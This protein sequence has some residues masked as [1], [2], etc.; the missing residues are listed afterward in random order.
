MDAL[1]YTLAFS[2]M[3]PR[4]C[5]TWGHPTTTG[6]EHMDFFLS[7]D[8]LELSEA[9]A[10]YTEALLRPATLAT[11]Y[12]RPARPEPPGSRTELGLDPDANL[13]AC[14]QTLFKL[15]P[16]FDRLLAEILR[17]DPDGLLLLIEGRASEW[18]QLLR[19]R[20]ARTMPDVTDRI[21]WLKPLPREDYLRL[22]G[23]ADVVLDT[24]HFG[25]GNS[26]YEAL[27]MGA[28]VVTLPGELLRSRITRALYAKGDYMDLVA[29]DEDDYIEI[30]VRLGRDQ[31]RRA[32]VRDRIAS[33][34]E[35]L[36]DDPDELVDF[37]EALATACG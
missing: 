17:R 10:H 24:P 22:L 37:E 26:S 18:T 36:F 7:S 32:S 1:T 9:D 19:E 33:A 28:P 25:G 6:S 34:R 2:R 31:A 3:A 14:P 30:A 12:E 35:A 11:F 21:R 8:L 23:A 5:A 16:A 20:F 13:Y 29:A 27:A 4:Q 15:H